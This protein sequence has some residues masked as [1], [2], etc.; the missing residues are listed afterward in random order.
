M[1][2]LIA[3][4][5]T[6]VEDRNKPYVE[7]I[8]AHDGM[9]RLIRPG[10][11]F[12]ELSPK[13]ILLTG[14]GDLSEE[15]YDHPVSASERKT[16]GRIEP[17]RER[18]EFRVLTWAAEHDVPTLGICRGCQMMNIFAH[19]VL[20][21]D[22]PIWQKRFCVSPILQH[23]NDE[24]FSAPAHEIALEG[25]S[26]L[27]ELFGGVKTMGVNSSH[28]QALSRCGK[29]LKATARAPDGIIEAIENPTL[30]FWIGVQFHPERMWKRQPVFSSLFRCFIECARQRTW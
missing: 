21:P 30:A 19:G 1:K 14:G 2:P 29:L 15:H 9:V 27:R 13:G 25:K 28:H 4:V 26:R 24:D 22:I 6:S 8:Q 12:E 20:I 17:E 11:D 3:I 18:Y 7:T 5:A 23:R 10:D 16:L